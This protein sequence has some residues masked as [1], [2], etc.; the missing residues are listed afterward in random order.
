ME[1]NVI[2]TD[3]KDL[4]VSCALYFHLS[5][6]GRGPLLERD[7]LYLYRHGERVH[8]FTDSCVSLGLDIC[9]C[10][11]S[12]PTM[13]AAT[14]WMVAPCMTAAKEV[15]NPHHIPLQVVRPRILMLPLRT[16]WTSITWA[17]MHK[18]MPYHFILSFEAFTAFGTRAAGDRAV[19]RARGRV[20]ICVGT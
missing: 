15:T 16:K 12:L 20:D 1:G 2:E 5:P 4:A 13:P 9:V 10:Q 8:A 6:S 14:T 7:R 11:R 17:L 19:M 18:S 3:A